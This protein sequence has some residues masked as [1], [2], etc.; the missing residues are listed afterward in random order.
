MPW[1]GWQPGVGVQQDGHHPAPRQHRQVPH[2]LQ[3]QQQ[4]QVERLHREEQPAV[5]HAGQVQVA[6][7]M[8]KPGGL[9][10]RLGPLAHLAGVYKV[11]Q[12]CRGR[13]SSCEEGKGISWLWERI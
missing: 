13:I 3:R 11:Y 1:D 8:N 9:A 10:H 12:V 7:L 2:Q 6:G 5:A 4:T